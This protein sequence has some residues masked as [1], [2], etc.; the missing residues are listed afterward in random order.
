MEYD[1]ELEKD[2]KEG[3]K[4]KAMEEVQIQPEKTVRS[5]VRKDGRG[6]RWWQEV[7]AAER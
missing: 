5:E 6:S 7:R 2:E 1:D 4:H 3:V